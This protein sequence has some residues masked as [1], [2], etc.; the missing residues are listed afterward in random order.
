LV[1]LFSIIALD[2]RLFLVHK[3]VPIFS[4]LSVTYLSRAR[5]E[6]RTPSRARVCVW[7]P[8]P[9]TS[10]WFP[11]PPTAAVPA[12][13]TSAIALPKKDS[14]NTKTSLY[15]CD[16]RWRF[17]NRTTVTRCRA[18]RITGS[19]LA[20]GSEHSLGPTDARSTSPARPGSWTS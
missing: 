15:R 2:F 8:L 13:C 7:R 9:R 18:F 4:Y 3:K 6:R 10:P 20:V 19:T 5:R 17:P 12:I 1:S 16:L 14:A 11:A